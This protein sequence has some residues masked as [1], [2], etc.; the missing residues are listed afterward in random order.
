[1]N[2]CYCLVF[3][4]KMPDIMENIP[5]LRRLRSSGY[6]PICRGPA[7]THIPD[8]ATNDIYLKAAAMK[9]SDQTAYRPWKIHMKCLYPEA[10]RSVFFSFPQQHNKIPLPKWQRRDSDYQKRIW[11]FLYSP[12][13]SEQ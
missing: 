6:V 1:M 4:R 8:R 2:Q 11:I 3:E 12:I 10:I 13:S 9:S 5:D 7:H